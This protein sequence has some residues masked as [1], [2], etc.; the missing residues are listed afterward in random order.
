[1]RVGLDDEVK[2]VVTVTNS[3]EEAHEATLIV[4]IPEMLEYRG[5]DEKVRPTL[6]G[7]L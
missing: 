5:T 2:L 1:M 3:G 7:V 4:T 6:T